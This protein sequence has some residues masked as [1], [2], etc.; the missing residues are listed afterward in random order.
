[1]RPPVLRVH[2]DGLIVDSFAGG[3]GAST[4]IEWATGR[5][6]DIAINH[7]REALAMHE[8]NH[9]STRHFCE[10]VWD[11]DPKKACGGKPVEL[12]WFSPDCRHFSKAKGAKPVDNGVRGLAWVA[13]KWAK[14]V[15][16]RILCVENV[17]ELKT[18]GPLLADNTPCPMRKGFTFRRWLAQL[19]NLGYQVDM[20]EL[21]AADY[22]APT[23]RKRL[24]I[25]ARC[26][27]RPVE[28]PDATHG[29]ACGLRPHRTAAEVIDWS[30]PVASI[31]DRPRPL[32]ENTLLRV[33]RGVQ[34]FVV[35][36]PPFMASPRV[37]AFVAKHFGGNGTPG[38]S[39]AAPLGTI[40]TQDHN[41]LVTVEL[42]E[43]PGPR[44]GL[45]GALLVAFYGTQ[46]RPSLDR[47]LPT[48][49]TKD[50][51]ALVTLGG[52]GR[53]INDLGMR[54]FSPRELAAAQGFPTDYIL[55]PEVDGRRLSR[56]DQ[57]RMLGNS[58]PPP[59]AAAVVRANLAEQ[60]S[61][62]RPAEQLRLEVG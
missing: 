56:G 13:V 1:M 33:A 43:K 58:V 7:D 16:P 34:R 24:F 29:R 22:G 17:V 3:G 31:F 35:E 18:W 44:A 60:R 45:V 30:I 11:V 10:S 54:M 28:W 51:F 55:D 47:P 53:Y 61:A 2:L 26:D 42:G 59:V 46:Q 6:P 23:S 48:I 12:A 27:G 19:T 49:T 41:H 36:H 9:P 37:A 14:T 32:A 38:S 5:S 25:V 50:R 52:E 4:G 40:T 8:A 39:L 21:V 62:R 15:R 20:R 57:V